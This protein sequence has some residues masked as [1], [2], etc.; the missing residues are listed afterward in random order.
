M[1][2]KAYEVH[3]HGDGGADGTDAQGK[4]LRGEQVLAAV[5]AERPTDTGQV[6]HG[7]GAG[8]GRGLGRGS[9]VAVD[10]GDGNHVEE[11]S[12]VEQGDCLQGDADDE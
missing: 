6:D 2:D 4:Q 11:D 8:G 10:P 5:P 3:S 9:F 7:D 12:D 1:E